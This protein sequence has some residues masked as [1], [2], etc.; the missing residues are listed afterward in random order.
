M[1][2]DSQFVKKLL[3]DNKDIFEP[4]IDML[5]NRLKPFLFVTLLFFFIIIMIF[6][7]LI[8]VEIKRS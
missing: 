5:F 6:I 1:E 7:L 4:L 8:S 2:E 3:D